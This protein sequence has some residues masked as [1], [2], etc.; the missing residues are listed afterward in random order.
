MDT[1]EQV[2]HCKNAHCE[3]PL[4]GSPPR[5]LLCDGGVCDPTHARITQWRDQHT[6]PFRLLYSLTTGLGNSHFIIRNLRG[7]GFCS[8]CMNEEEFSRGAMCKCEIDGFLALWNS[9]LRQAQSFVGR[10]L[11][12]L[13][14][15]SFD[16][17]L[18][19]ISELIL[20]RH[21]AL[22]SR[23]LLEEEDFKTISSRVETWT[24]LGNCFASV[25]TGRSL[26]SG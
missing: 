7:E 22:F 15:T 14:I 9:A 26:R 17:A 5:C 19:T 1:S 24:A 25:G 23:Y 8:C 21:N 13:P 6:N 10:H 20:S 3:L 18:R 16:E 12:L 4:I 2:A 11:Q